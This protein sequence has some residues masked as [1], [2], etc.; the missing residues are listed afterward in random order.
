M[1]SRSEYQNQRYNTLKIMKKNM[2]LLILEMQL[3]TTVSQLMY[4]WWLMVMMNWLEDKLLSW[5]VL[6]IRRKKIGL[7]ILMIGVLDTMED[8]PVKSQNYFFKI[9]RTIEENLDILWVI[10]PHSIPNYFGWLRIGITNTTTELSWTR[11]MIRLCNSLYSK[12]LALTF[13]ISQK[14][15]ISTTR[16]TQTKMALQTKKLNIE[17][18]HL[19]W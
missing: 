17:E 1:L 13:Y 6:I 3:I 2:R 14:Y 15:A 4:L 5:S 18:K 7:F 12:W 8:Y 16:G 11:C 9:T 19:R 10:S